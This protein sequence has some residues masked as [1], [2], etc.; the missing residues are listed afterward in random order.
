MRAED[1]RRQLLTVAAECFAQK[2]YRATTTAGLAAAAGVTAPVLYHHFRGKD[3][4]FATLLGEARQAAVEGWRDAV[5]SSGINALLGPDAPERAKVFEQL[6]LGV[7]TD[8]HRDTRVTAAVVSGLRGLAAG[9][10]AA[11]AQLQSTG[12]IASAISP[13]QMAW[14]V[15]EWRLGHRFREPLEQALGDE[16]PLPDTGSLLAQLITQSQP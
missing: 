8:V 15:L 14:L 6:V 13:T 9:I 2:G 1:R 12:A 16:E 11:I 4:L 3:E 10:T 5:A 7:I